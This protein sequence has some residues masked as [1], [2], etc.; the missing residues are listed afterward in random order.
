MARALSLP[1][2]N[3]QTKT[4]INFGFLCFVG[5]RKVFLFPKECADH[6]ARLTTG[7]IMLLMNIC[8]FVDYG[9]QEQSML[10]RVPVAKSLVTWEAQSTRG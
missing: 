3:C 7:L 4:P 8:Q 1:T 6:M 5:R 10:A 2:K 9:L